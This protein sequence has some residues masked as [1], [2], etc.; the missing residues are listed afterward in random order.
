M[1]TSTNDNRLLLALKEISTFLATHE[2]ESCLIGGIAVQFRG[3]PRFTSDIDI[4]IL[5]DLEIQ[6]KTVDL[7]LAQYSSIVDNPKELALSAQLLPICIENITI[8][9][10]F[11]LTGF[12]QQVIKR[13]SFE[14]LTD[15]FIIKVATS[16]DL[17][18]FKCLAGRPKDIQDIDSILSK[19]KNVLDKAYITNVL[20]EL[21]RLLET[22]QLLS[23]FYSRLKKQ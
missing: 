20:G 6:E 1:L 13:A 9:L 21:E 5:S 22:D 12:E 8:D 15:N 10:S 23:L 14:T 3:E 4:C 18:I 7:I 16:E 17:I 2:I 19:N 11:G